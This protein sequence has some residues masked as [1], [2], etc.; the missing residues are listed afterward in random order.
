MTLEF[1]CF[2]FLRT[3]ICSSNK[4]EVM[5]MRVSPYGAL[6]ATTRAAPLTWT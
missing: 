1:D 4:V 2:F 6:T 5:T 3:G